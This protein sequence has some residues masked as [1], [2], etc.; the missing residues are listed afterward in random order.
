[1]KF[2]TATAVFL[3]LFFSISYAKDYEIVISR[4]GG[5]LYWV[6]AEDLYIQTE[7]CFEY[8]ESDKATLR[9]DGETGELVFSEKNKC[10]VKGLYRK[11]QLGAGTYPVTVSREDDNWYVFAG[12]LVA[13]NTEG[14]LSLV[15]NAAAELKIDEIGNGT[16][17]LEGEECTVKG[18]YSKVQIQ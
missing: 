4:V 10:D 5:N 2:F 3:A 12:R 1:M 8:S 9:M 14:C 13:L 16:L 7:Y 15:E 6:Q 18:I 17:T 11:N